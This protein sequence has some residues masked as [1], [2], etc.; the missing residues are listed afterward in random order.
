MFES[1]ANEC[2][3]GDLHYVVKS[4]TVDLVFSSDESI[5]TQEALLLT[6]KPKLAFAVVLGHFPDFENNVVDQR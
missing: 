4:V 5:K 6:S 1:V 3:L 2:D